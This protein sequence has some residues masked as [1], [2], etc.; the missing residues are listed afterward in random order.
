MNSNG[1]DTMHGKSLQALDTAALRSMLML[2]LGA[3][4][5]L[6][7]ARIQEITNILA[8]R[9]QIAVPDVD[10]AWKD[11]QQNYISSE[12]IH[13]LEQDAPQPQTPAPRKR[14]WPQIILIAAILVVLFAS[15]TNASSFNLWN[16]VAKW[17]SETFGFTFGGE[18]SSQD[19]INLRNEALAPLWDTLLESGI[20][21]PQLPTYLP[22]EFEQ[23][24]LIENTET[25]FW[26]AIYESEGNLIRIQV[27]LSQDDNWSDVQKDNTDP[28]PYI[29]NDI[30]FYIMTNM[31][32]W[33]ASWSS[34][35]YEYLI[36]GATE[37][38]LY[39]M[40]ESVHKEE[41][42]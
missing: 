16:A 10:T 15:A 23:V 24:D 18:M 6:D 2:E 28:E 11:F 14:R 33:V 5:E 29:W 25:G 8:E 19:R 9:E 36:S 17:T 31:G 26:S 12:P 22:E 41:P 4:G 20:S 42:Q 7:V 34:G 3:E 38:E 37:S 30:E 40:I 39:D 32:Q 35:Q 13:T 27:Q 21:A 1:P